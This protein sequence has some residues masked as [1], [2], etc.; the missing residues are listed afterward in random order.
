MKTERW[1][2]YRGF[3]Y[4]ICPVFE[5]TEQRVARGDWRSKV[6]AYYF[7]L[8]MPRGSGFMRMRGQIE[9]EEFDSKETAEQAAEASIDAIADSL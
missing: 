9:P 8:Y 3:R 2:Y 6:V 4:E 1:I 5:T 7:I